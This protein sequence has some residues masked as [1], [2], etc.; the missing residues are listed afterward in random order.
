MFNDTKKILLISI[1]FFLLLVVPIFSFS[2]DMWDGVII[3][4]AFRS[5]NFSGIEIY[6]FES[7]WILQY[8]LSKFIINLSFFFNITY[9]N[10][11]GFFIYIIFLFFFFET[12]HLFCFTSGLIGIRIVQEVDNNFKKLA[13]YI[14]IILSFGFKPLLVFNPLLSLCY[15]FAKNKKYNLSNKTIIILILAIISFSIRLIF[16]PTGQYA[17]HNPLIFFQDN[18][19]K[20]F[21]SGIY[22]YSSYPG[23]SIILNL[24]LI[25]ILLLL[26]FKIVINKNLTIKFF[27]ILIPLIILFLASSIPYISVGKW[28]VFWDVKDWTHRQALLIS[29]PFSLFVLILTSNIL[30][31]FQISSDTKLK[32]SNIIFTIFLIINLSFFSLSII[33]RM[34]RNVFENNL[35]FSLKNYFDKPIK[36]GY[37]QFIVKNDLPDYPHYRNI[38]V[39][40]LLYRTFNERSYYS[41]FSVKKDNKFKIDSLLSTDDRYQEKYMFDNNIKCNTFI[42]LETNNFLKFF[43]KLKNIFRVQSPKVNITKV[44]QSCN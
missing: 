9:K 28:A 44:E 2:G 14:L 31:F 40:Y 4:Y 13:G 20:N 15:D 16:P 27:Y 7:K 42:F 29:I 8:F 11:N 33:E 38:E 21:L 17:G 32:F 43:D 41:K 12:L 25:F 39:N 6:F 10:L 37:V 23:I 5:K 35:I 36:P 30:N 26:K 1:F 18:F 22:Y 24:F 3:D 34:N 19:V